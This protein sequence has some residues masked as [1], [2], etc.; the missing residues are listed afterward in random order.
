MR[1]RMLIIDDQMPPA[2]GYVSI[3]TWFPGVFEIHKAR[4]FVADVPVGEG[5]KSALARLKAGRY[6]VILADFNL[7]D[8]DRLGPQYVCEIRN[9]LEGRVAG[10]DGSLN[11]DAYII[12]TASGWDE[13]GQNALKRML[14]RKGLT[15]GLDGSTADSGSAALQLRRELE[16]FL[17]LREAAA[18]EKA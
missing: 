15:R 7:S 12:G 2:K 10:E 4:T 3:E 11:K 18:Q 13:Q 14:K 17:A 8:G 5:E 16:K 1:Y 9:C 6:D